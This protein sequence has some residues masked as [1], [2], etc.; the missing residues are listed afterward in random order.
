MFVR[1]SFT[2]TICIFLS[3]VV[4]FFM[5]G[6]HSRSEATIERSDVELMQVGVFHGNEIFAESGEVWLG[7]YPTEN[8]HALLPS[9]ITVDAAYDPLYDDE[10]EKTG[11]QVLVAGDAEPLFLIRGLKTLKPGPVKTLTT[12]QAILTPGKSMHFGLGRGDS[13]QLI[14]FGE[15]YEDSIGITSLQEYEI[16]I[17]EGG[18]SQV[19]V[20]FS[21]TDAAVPSLLWAG[22]LDHDGKLDLLINAAF[23]YN[24]YT[25]PVL[26]LSSTAEDGELLDKVA[27]FFATGC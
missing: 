13:Y 17:R 14:V 23:H 16:E 26:F 15:R 5:F 21:A 1:M 6:C 12:E 4:C 20:S 3:G 11:K 10:D 9:T 2:I 19:L 25:A 8:G 7:L 24:I 22:D 18:R 27:M